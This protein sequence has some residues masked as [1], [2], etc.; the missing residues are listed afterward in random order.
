MWSLLWCNTCSPLFSW[1]ALRVCGT[2]T[3]IAWSESQRQ[4]NWSSSFPSEGQ[5][6]PP[7]LLSNFGYV[8]RYFRLAMLYIFMFILLLLHWGVHIPLRWHMTK[9]F[10]IIKYLNNCTTKTSEDVLFVLGLQRQ[11]YIGHDI[12]QLRRDSF[13]WKWLGESHLIPWTDGSKWLCFGYWVFF[14]NIFNSIYT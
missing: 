10:L 2:Q 1:M 8:N 11:T 3:W 5:R 9:R 7:I 12:L 13:S 6:P 4:F 14:S